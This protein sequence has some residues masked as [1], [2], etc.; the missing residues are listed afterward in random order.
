MLAVS[1]TSVYIYGLLSAPLTRRL[2]SLLIKGIEKLAKKKAKYELDE[3]VRRTEMLAIHVLDV[4]D[5]FQE[6]HKRRK[7][8]ESWW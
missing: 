7:R 5:L 2:P 8:S 1:N 3:S 4:A 6:T